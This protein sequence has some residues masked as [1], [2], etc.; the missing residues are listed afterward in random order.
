[1]AYNG[2]FFT[3]NIGAGSLAPS[4]YTYVTTDDTEVE[5][6]T[7]DYFLADLGGVLKVNDLIT[8]VCT[9]GTTQFRVTESTLVTVTVAVLWAS[10]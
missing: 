8:A 1:M 5:V 2:Q 7:A 10:V 3:G 6:G 4:F 9:D